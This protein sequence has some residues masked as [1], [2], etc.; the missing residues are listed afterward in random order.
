MD[1]IGPQRGHGTQQRVATLMEP[2]RDR[3]TAGSAAL[4]T[5]R[6]TSVD[7]GH[8]ALYLGELN[9]GSYLKQRS[10]PCGPQMEYIICRQVSLHNLKTVC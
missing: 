9:L 7:E 6:S 2:L 10:H 3:V 8:S 5:P 4:G 1:V